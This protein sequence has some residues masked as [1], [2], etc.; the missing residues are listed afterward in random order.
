M[1]ALGADPD[2]S[3]INGEPIAGAHLPDK[4]RVVFE[5]HGPRFATT[6]IGIA[7]PDSRI[8]RIA[9]IIEHGGKIPD[10]HMLV[11]ISPFGARDCPVNGR[12]QFL[13]LF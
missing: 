6:V 11:A 2:H 12:S 13:D 10:V 5:V 9:G 4:M 7:K 1:E 8:E 3:Q